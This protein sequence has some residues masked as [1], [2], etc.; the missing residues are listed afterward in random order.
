MIHLRTVVEIH[1]D[2]IDK[3]G[4]SR[5]IR[6]NEGLEAAIARPNMTFDSVELYPLPEDKAAAV[7][8]SL[9]IN[10]P[11]IDGN[12]RIA[13]FML[14]LFLI[15]SSFDIEA[16][17]NDKYNM[18]IAASKGELTMDEIPEWIKKHLIKLDQ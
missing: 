17:I 13:Y 14:R 5:G 16:S 8:E 12:K 15:E 3:H 10:H 2:L 9:V 18:T 11:F 7:F 6:S 1:S 4:G